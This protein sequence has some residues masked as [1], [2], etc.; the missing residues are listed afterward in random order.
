MNTLDPW[1][2]LT[3][4]SGLSPLKIPDQL[5][6][7]GALLLLVCHFFDVVHVLYVLIIMPLYKAWDVVQR[8]RFDL[9]LGTT[10]HI[11]LLSLHRMIYSL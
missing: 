9:F 2:L 6:D 1:D 3:L 4:A 7:E 10:G 5:V 11:C 8:K